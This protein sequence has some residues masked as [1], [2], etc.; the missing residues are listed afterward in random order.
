MKPLIFLN[1][2]PIQY[3]APLYKEIA[4]STAIDLTVW[5]CS[6]RSIRG[7]IDHG[8]GEKVKW[9]IPMLEGYKSV[10]IK[11]YSRRK[12]R[13]GFFSLMNFGVVK[14]LYKHPESV[15]IVHGWSYVTHILTII[16]GKI[17]GHKVCLRAETPYNQELRKNRMLTFVKRIMLRFL[18]LFIHRFLYIGK[19]NKMFYQSLSVQESELLF[20]PYSVDN[21]RFRT[22]YHTTDKER[23]HF[24][25]HLPAEKKIILYSG[26]YIAKKRPLDLLKAFQLL[27]NRDTILVFVGEGELRAE[28]EKYIQDNNLQDNV[29]LT[30]FI[31][32]KQIPMYYRA[33]DI[34]VMCSGQGETWG[35]SVNEAMNF[36]LPVLV[37]DTCGCAYDLVD[38]G[39][40]GAIFE[41][42]NVSTLS[43]LLGE[44]LGKSEIEKQEIEKTAFEIID[45]YSYSQIIAQLQR[46]VV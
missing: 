24:I 38:S 42:G 14:M 25:L 7:E 12:D 43:T 8:F 26:K 21:K 44:Y 17:F 19:Q 9:D 30:G 20:V 16:F 11:N 34:F 46:L 41:T 29:I 22:L 6:D 39:K 28:M 2:H 40:N 23:C 37:S 45:R 36:G 31:N 1:S 27:N 35:L 33:A 10:F 3:F 5:Y 15:I 4:T 13:N 18:F 32:Q